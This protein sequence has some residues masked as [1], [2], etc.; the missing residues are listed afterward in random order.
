ML[1]SL[2]L[3]ITSLI[4]F[5]IL[6]M[7]DNGSSQYI[8]FFVFIS[9][10]LLGLF[11]YRQ[12]NQDAGFKQL[13]GEGFKIFVVIAFFMVIYSWIFY[14]YNPQILEEAIKFNEEL[15]IKQGNKTMPEIEENTKKLRQIFIPMMLAFNTIKYLLMGTLVTVV[16]SGF[17]G[18]KQFQTV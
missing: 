16:A 17:W 9:G 13:F 5:Y 12:L 10:L 11:Q 15:I 8:I 7:P 3:I 14:K 4:C 1:L 6:E 2:L 18:K